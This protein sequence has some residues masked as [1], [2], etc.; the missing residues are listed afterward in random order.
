LNEL[1][2]VIINYDTDLLR[3]VGLEYHTQD[4]REVQAAK[5]RDGEWRNVPAVRSVS[6]GYGTAE[7]DGTTWI[8]SDKGKRMSNNE[9]LAVII[10]VMRLLRLGKIDRTTT[11]IDVLR[12]INKEQ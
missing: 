5:V 11:N 9:K 4:T 10:Q 6:R 8:Y 3:Y 12:L 7:R 1:S 2:R